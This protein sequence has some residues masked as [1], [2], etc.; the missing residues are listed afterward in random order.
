MKKELPVSLQLVELSFLKGSYN[1]Q[2]KSMVAR[3]RSFSSSFYED[4]VLRN[5]HNLFGR[6]INERF[7]ILGHARTGSNYLFDGLMSSKSVT[8]YHEIF[9]DHNRTIGQDFEKVLSQV[10]RKESKETRLVGF[11]LFYNHLT[12]EEWI[13]FLQHDEF[14]IIHLTRANRLR[15]IVSLDIAFKTDE[16]TRSSHSKGRQLVEKRIT[17]D[18]TKLIGRLEKIQSQEAF[19]RERFKGRPMFEVVYEELVTI[20]KVV[21]QNTGD[22]LGVNDI[23]FTKIKIVKQNTEKL[24][25]LIINFDEVFQCLKNS[26]FAD[27]LND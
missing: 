6:Q 18:T 14:K 13:Q 9:A 2:M 26:Q 21:F 10:Y 25:Q 17:L 15:T 20:P 27:C 11:K 23:D 22:F 19:A 5:Y 1:M 12:E 3:L 4:F 16:W 24:E 8:G 7:V